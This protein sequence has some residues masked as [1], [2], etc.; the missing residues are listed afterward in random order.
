MTLP[1]RHGILLNRDQAGNPGDLTDC[2]LGLNGYTGPYP[3]N[4]YAAESY[5]RYVAW[6]TLNSG[7]STEEDLSEYG[8]EAEYIGSPLVEN[9]YSRFN[10]TDQYVKCKNTALYDT[11]SEFSIIAY[12]KKESF[13][14]Y[15]CIASKWDT[16]NVANSSWYLLVKPGGIVCFG[17]TDDGSAAQEI[18][19]V[20]PILTNTTYKIAVTFKATESKIY[21]NN[22]PVDT[23]GDITYEH[24][25]KSTTHVNIARHAS[26]NQ[27]FDGLIGAVILFRHALTESELPLYP[28]IDEP[29]DPPAPRLYRDIIYSW[30][31]DNDVHHFTMDYVANETS[32]PNG[33][34]SMTRNRVTVDSSG[35]ISTTGLAFSSNNKSSTIITTPNVAALTNSS[36]SAI[37]WVKI[38]Q[39]PQTGGNVDAW[40]GYMARVCPSGDYGLGLSMAGPQWTGTGDHWL[41]FSHVMADLNGNPTHAPGRINVKQQNTTFVLNE[42]NML[43]VTHSL[44]DLENKLYVNGSL[45]K[46][47]TWPVDTYTAFACFNNNNN[48]NGLMFGVAAPSNND[49]EGR[50]D[51]SFE[52]IT[53]TDKILSNSEVLELYNA[54]IT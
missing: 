22:I 26:N 46:S 1:L 30:S 51:G 23:V 4:E 53:I 39:L 13:N 32:K 49:R 45:V 44:T 50:V 6:W 16:N 48:D 40:H 54:G 28:N 12:I 43:V 47:V 8:L 15:Q 36:Y 7:E 2:G 25:N 29:I 3:Q 38:A 11:T 42:Y 31:P 19:T 37:L 9:G 17:L 52:E 27:Y 41:Q 10:G 18:C 24:I 20:D 33:L 5:T 34:S 35:I 14:S 21:I